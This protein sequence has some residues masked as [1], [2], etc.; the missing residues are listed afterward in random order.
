[1]R[2]IDFGLSF[3]KL[4]Q[5]ILKVNTAS[6]G[7]KKKQFRSAMIPLAKELISLYAL[8]LAKYQKVVTK[9]TLPALFTNN[10]QLKTLLNHACSYTT[11]YTHMKRLK[12]LGFI[13]DYK[14]HGTNRNYE[15]QINPEVLHLGRQY[16]REDI[17]IMEAEIAALRTSLKN[18]EVIP[19]KL[20]IPNESE[21][22]YTLPN[23]LN[24]QKASESAETQSFNSRLPDNEYLLHNLYSGKADSDNE[25]KLLTGNTGDGENCAGPDSTQHG[26]RKS[27]NRLSDG[28]RLRTSA[29]DKLRMRREKIDFYIFQFW[30]L[31]SNLLFKDYN[32][33]PSQVERSQKL[34]RFYYYDKVQDHQLD[35]VHEIYL[36]TLS[37]KYHKIKNNSGLFVP[38]PWKY[39]DTDFVYGFKNDI[40]WMQ[41]GKDF[42][43]RLKPKFE[44]QACINRIHKNLQR[45][46]KK[47]KDEFKLF[48]ICE[49]RL[50][51][52]GRE[53]VMEFI[54]EVERLKKSFEVMNKN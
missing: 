25:N 1:M 40:N 30:S 32:L 19:S 28:R 27:F 12:E 45:E 10:Q 6:A 15:I 36:D 34:I 53:I 38:L 13:T 49:D 41:K 47:R 48:R 3:K 22:L 42:M 50:S 17:Q 5:F 7:D 35:N 8:S 26:G 4:D 54:N 18:K 21:T 29:D 2:V 52:Y 31:A 23:N 9:D 46:P 11:I 20:Q 16:V 14:F 33:T 43:T 44:L 51:K 37:Y 24:T 39:F